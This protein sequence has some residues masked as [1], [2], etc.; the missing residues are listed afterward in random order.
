MHAADGAK[1]ARVEPV[2]QNGSGQPATADGQPA[3]PGFLQ[4]SRVAAVYGG[5]EQPPSEA[6]QNI[7]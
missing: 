7:Q 5:A 2:A 6:G 1:R 4:S 3:L